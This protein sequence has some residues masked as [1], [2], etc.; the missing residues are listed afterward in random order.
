MGG[1][2]GLAMNGMFGGLLGAGM[3]AMAARAS[4]EIQSG[5]R[6]DSIRRGKTY[7]AMK[8]IGLASQEGMIE[9][10][11]GASFQLTDDP[12]IKLRNTSSMVSKK[13][14]RT[15]YEIDSSNPLSK[16]TATVAKPLAYFMNNGVL[17][18][19]NAKNPRDKKS[20][21]STLGTLVNALQ[22]DASDI[23]LV[24]DRARQLTKKSGV[25]KQV[26][27]D[28]FRSIKNT[29]DENELETI[30]KGIDILYA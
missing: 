2:V 27:V 28:Y 19:A 5:Q 3:G 7:E 21:E 22:T 14:D 26:M 23:N 10:D 15:T 17:R 20:F 6:Q 29:L 4:G 13:K 18:W 16:R 11:D 12:S 24:Y 25:S 30:E 1:A 8:A 9:F